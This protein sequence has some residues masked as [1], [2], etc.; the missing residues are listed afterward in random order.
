MVPQKYSRSGVFDNCNTRKDEGGIK[1]PSF[2]RGEFRELMNL[3]VERDSL[4]LLRA[5]R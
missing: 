4:A 5:V 2:F 3:I 1:K